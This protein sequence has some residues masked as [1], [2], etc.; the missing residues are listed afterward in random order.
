MRFYCT[1]LFIGILLLI[2]KI[3]YACPPDANSVGIVLNNGEHTSFETI[4]TYGSLGVNYLKDFIAPVAGVSDT[5]LQKSLNKK[6][7]SAIFSLISQSFVYDPTAT[8]S[9]SVKPLFTFNNDTLILND[10]WALS[11]QPAFRCSLSVS[12]DTLYISYL[13]VPGPVN[14]WTPS[15]ETTLKIQTHASVIDTVYKSLNL[16]FKAVPYARPVEEIG[17]RNATKDFYSFL[18]IPP[19]ATYKYRAHSDSTVMVYLSYEQLSETYRFSSRITI[20]SDP[21]NNLSKANLFAVLA[22]ELQWLSNANICS[23]SPSLLNALLA[24]TPQSGG[25]CYWSKQDS[26]ISLNQWFLIN[27]QSLLVYGARNGCGL[28][29]TFD[30]PASAL[31]ASS[32]VSDVN[33]FRYSN[34]SLMKAF[35]R[36]RVL[37]IVSPTAFDNIR[38]YNFLGRMV[39]SCNLGSPSSRAIVPLSGKAGIISSG[40]HILVLGQRQKIIFCQSLLF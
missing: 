35:V 37:E 34:G 32:S 16:C 1:F 8:S 22:A 26:V 36:N 38:L 14:D 15:V 10:Y 6:Q 21:L 7:T 17:F 18:P 39:F 19:Y 4:E 5:F 27:E 28:G 12:N 9:F 29:T 31:A 11:E 20:S 40:G 13:P 25:I 33:S 24:K 23:F 2:G 3:A 30:L